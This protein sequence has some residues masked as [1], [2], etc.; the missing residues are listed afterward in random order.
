MAALSAIKASELSLMNTVLKA[1]FLK[2][3][4]TKIPLLIEGKLGWY[5]W[6]C[7]CSNDC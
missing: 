6:L 4:H 1:A 7:S 5:V 2:V 3:Q